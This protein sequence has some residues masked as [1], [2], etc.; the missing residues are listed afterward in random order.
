MVLEIPISYIS[1]ILSRAANY[2]ISALGLNVQYGYSGLFN[3]GIVVFSLIGAY[4]TAILTT[5]FHADFFITILVSILLAAITA[6]LI[7]I[8][9]LRTRGDYFAIVTLG[10][11]YV[12]YSLVLNWNAE[13]IRGA[14]GIPA[15]KRPVI[16]GVSF[17]TFEMLML[18]SF[19]I[20]ALAFVLANRIANSPYGRMLR[21][22]RE[23][24][25]AA[26][27]L[28][29]DVVKY[30][31]SAFMIGAV[32]AAVGGSLYA[33]WATY[34]EP[35][36]FSVLESVYVLFAVLIGGKGNLLGSV[37]G[38]FIFILLPEPLRFLNLPPHLIGGIRQ[39]MLGALLLFVVL[40]KP[41][42]L[43]PEKIRHHGK[44]PANE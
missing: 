39:L 42:G 29:K 30:K 18:L 38:G 35:R 11:A 36:Q 32:F 1:S 17:A 40:Y 16:F 28:G 31:L 21:A 3:L 13:P 43:I 34:I 41:E 8:P 15:I 25:D 10:F 22:I 26:M 19:A 14:L 44:Q 23:D 27:S 33:Y 4:T 37:L 7:G 6:F 9:S 2:A 12:V 20:L 24:E 5:R